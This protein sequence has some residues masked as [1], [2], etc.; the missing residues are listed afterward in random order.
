M[1][2]RPLEIEDAPL[3]LEWIHDGRV[4]CFYRFDASKYTIENVKSFISDSMKYNKMVQPSAIHYAIAENG[5]EY[6]GTISLKNIDY[7]NKNAEYAIVLRHSSQGKGLA[8]KATKE[9]LEIAFKNMG[10]HRVYLNVLADNYHA[11]RV[12]EKNGFEYE[13]KWK[14]H[15]RIK[16]EWKSLCWYAITSD[17]WKK[18][19]N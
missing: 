8:S 6:Q 2:I 16:D 15:L 17:M 19:R 4:N 3:M 10:L 9:L 1:H 18:V 14:E 7:I 13:G 11:I 12:Y 5:G